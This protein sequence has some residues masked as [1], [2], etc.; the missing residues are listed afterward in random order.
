MQSIQRISRDLR[1]G[2]MDFGIVAAVEWEA[3]EFT[4]R[5]GIP[6]EVS[7]TRQDIDLEPDLAVAVFRIFQESLTNIT[8]HAQASHVWVRLDTIPAQAQDWLELEIRDNGFGIMPSDLMKL[9]SFGIRG[10][11]ERASFLGGKLTVNR[12]REIGTAGQGTI[13]RLSIPLGPYR[14]DSAV[15]PAAVNP[16]FTRM[17]GQQS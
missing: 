16:S 6:C 10:M 3:G 8:K 14:D 15:T 17:K 13:V 7:C 4:K 2:I 1:P 5:L 12:T 11:V 9:N